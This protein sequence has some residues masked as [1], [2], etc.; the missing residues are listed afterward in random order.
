[1]K[2]GVPAWSAVAVV[3]KGNSV[4]GISRQFNTRDPGL[5]GGDSEIFDE[6]PA[7]TAKREL[8]EE[9]GIEAVELRCIDQWYG[10]RGQPV[11]AFHVT[12]WRGGRLRTSAEGKPF[13]SRPERLIVNTATYRNEAQRLLTLLGK[14]PILQGTGTG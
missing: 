5:P 13:W 2:P 1:M 4:L 12:R 10:E 7:D 14:L 3:F 9:T 6:H 11:F 8:Y